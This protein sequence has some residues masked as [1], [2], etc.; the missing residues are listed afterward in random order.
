MYKDVCRQVRHSSLWQKSVFNMRIGGCVV[1]VASVLNSGICRGSTA[2]PLYM[3][4]FDLIC[5][6]TSC[7]NLGIMFQVRFGTYGAV[8]IFYFL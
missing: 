5:P 3:T 8:S 1:C 6:G 7:T 4:L 2:I